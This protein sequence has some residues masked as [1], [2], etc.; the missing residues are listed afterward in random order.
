MIQTKSNN[1]S[2]TL[3][4]SSDVLKADSHSETWTATTGTRGINKS[5]SLPSGTREVPFCS[6]T[7]EGGYC[8]SVA[9]G[10]YSHNV[11]DA[12][13]SNAKLNVSFALSTERT[14]RPTVTVVIRYLY[15]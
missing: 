5:I 9:A 12:G 1:G 10:Y 8:L 15:K 3:A 13:T 14:D 6:V 4:E 2:Y 7:V 11:S